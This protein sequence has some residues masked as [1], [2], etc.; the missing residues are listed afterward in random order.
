MHL[1]NSGAAGLYILADRSY[2]RCILTQNE[3]P[4]MSQ[5]KPV[6][7]QIVVAL[8]QDG[9]V[10]YQANIPSLNAAIMMLER[11]KLEMFARQ[12]EADRKAAEAVIEVPPPG[13]DH[14]RIPTQDGLRIAG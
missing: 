5:P 9:T 2:L 7:A 8:H 6:V 10:A 1:T 13:F 3:V 14:T 4:E 12:M 11:A